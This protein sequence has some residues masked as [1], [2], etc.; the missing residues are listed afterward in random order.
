MAWQPG[1]DLAQVLLSMLH[2]AVD[3]LNFTRKIECLSGVSELQGDL[4]LH[5][6]IK[7]KKKAQLLWTFLFADRLV[8][9]VCVLLM[10]IGSMGYNV[11]MQV[12]VT[13]RSWHG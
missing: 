3:L 2:S 12:Y 11:W 8:G 4:E 7:Y 5:L 13:C 10:D 6:E 1:S 9:H